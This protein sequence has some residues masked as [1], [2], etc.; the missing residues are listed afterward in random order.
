MKTRTTFPLGIKDSMQDEFQCPDCKEWIRMEDAY[1]A[2]NN[3]T[4]CE[5]C[6]EQMDEALYARD[7]MVDGDINY[8]L[9]QNGKP[10]F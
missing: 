6:G 5:D 2:V 8:Q 4:Y 9:E 3:V 1:E 10:R 7:D